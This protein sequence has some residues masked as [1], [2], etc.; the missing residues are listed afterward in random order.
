MSSLK[1]CHYR[2]QPVSSAP[3]R[4]I[5]HLPTFQTIQIYIHN[6]YNDD[7]RSNV[8]LMALKLRQA[9]LS[10]Q[11]ISQVKILP[12][13]IS[14][15]SG[16][17]ARPDDI[18]LLEQ[19]PKLRVCHLHRLRSRAMIP[20]LTRIPV[21]MPHIQHLFIEELG[22]LDLVTFPRLESLV[23]SMTFVQPSRQHWH[24][25][26]FERISQFPPTIQMSGGGRNDDI[27]V[28]V[29]AFLEARSYES[30]NGRGRMRVGLDNAEPA[31]A[32]NRAIRS[33]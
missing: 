32:S 15:Y 9:K 24:I 7:Y 13:Y 22:I 26:V 19:L 4:G 33:K 29:Q 25:Y 8:C 20:H 14:H 5:S 11:G 30:G 18:G 27:G 3:P 31:V 10:N 21:I 1:G 28:A 12:S 23:L 17:V 2:N 16:S 6:V